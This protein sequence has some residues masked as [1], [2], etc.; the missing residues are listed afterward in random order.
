MQHQHI[1][2]KS[3]QHQKRDSNWHHNNDVHIRRAMIRKIILLLQRQHKFEEQQWKPKIPHMAK[4]LELHLYKSA[5]SFEVY[6]DI[7]TLEDR[8]IQIAMTLTR[9][10]KVVTKTALKTT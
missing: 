4:F 10:A 7:Y 5:S 2:E 9:H 6:S 1:Q 8:L 3:L